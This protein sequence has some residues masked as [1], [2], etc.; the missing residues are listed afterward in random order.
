MVQG[1]IAPSAPPRH[2]FH[3]DHQVSDFSPFR[4]SGLK[5]LVFRPLRACPKLLAYEKLPSPCPYLTASQ[6]PQSQ[7]P[8][9]PYFPT[10][11]SSKTVRTI[12]HNFETAGWNP[13][14]NPFSSSFWIWDFG[15][16]VFVSSRHGY[17]VVH[18]LG[19]CLTPNPWAE[20]SRLKNSSREES[21]L[22]STCRPL[23]TR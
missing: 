14:P 4:V 3:T 5:S 12:L 11:N 13:P 15:F 16:H 19:T 10:R 18:P 23:S 22:L 9:N 8:P 2:I 1:Q 7:L 21:P 17:P 20:T 6:P